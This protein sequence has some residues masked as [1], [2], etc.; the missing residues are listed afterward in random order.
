G[1]GR[2]GRSSPAERRRSDSPGRVRSFGD[3]CGRIGAVATPSDPLP[4]DIDAL[5]AA[6]VAER[7]ERRQAEARALS[8]E[9]MI[10]QLKLL[11]AK[12]RRERF[13]PSSERGKLLDQLELQLEELEA[14][15]AED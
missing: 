15:S 2:G 1:W 3:A 10:A 12:L 4:D 5:K 11:I 14:S 7:A 8:A 6:L 13:A 9:A